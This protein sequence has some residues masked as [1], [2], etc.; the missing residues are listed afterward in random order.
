MPSRSAAP[1]AISGIAWNGFADERQSAILS[2]GDRRRTPQLTVG[3]DD[4][5]VAAMD[6]VHD[7]SADQLDEDALHVHLSAQPDA[8]NAMPTSVRATPAFCVRLMRSC[9]NRYAASMVAIG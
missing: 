4:R 2:L 6:L 9:R 5:E 7:A 3:G 8:T 1:R